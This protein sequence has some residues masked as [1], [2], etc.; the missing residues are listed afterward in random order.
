[1]TQI[2]DFLNNPLVAPL[3][4][5]LVISLLDLLLGIYRSIQQGA[6]DWAKLPSV[7]DSMVLQK[8]IPLAVL[9]IASYFVTDGTAKTALEV[10]Y[11][12]GAG[13]ALAGAFADLIS[14]AT[15]SFTATT[16]AQDKG[17]IVT[18]SMGTSFPSTETPVPPPY[19]PPATTPNVPPQTANTATLASPSTGSGKTPAK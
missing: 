7:L 17:A 12:G 5:L 14:K 10:A 16:V 1:M 9:G 8:F 18:G 4:A 11:I 2:T 13:A 6:F 3:Y 15:G 19:V